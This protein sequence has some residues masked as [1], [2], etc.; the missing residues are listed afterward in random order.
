MSEKPEPSGT[1]IGVRVRRK[2]DRRHLQG[3]G[4][5][6]ADLAMPGLLEVAFLRSPVAHARLTGWRKAPGA[7]ARCFFLEDLEGL[8]PI[9]ARSSLKGYKVSEWPALARDKLRYVGEC[10]AACVAPTRAEAEDLAEACG[11]DYEELPAV[12]DPLAAR[13]AGSPLVHESW[14]DNLFLETF[15]DGDI[16][17]IARTAA[18]KVEREYATARQCM[19]PMEGKGLLAWWDDRADQLVVHTSTQVP[20][21]I[22]TGLAE[23]LG[24]E[25][26]RVRI[27]PPDVGGGF[28][29]K[30]ILQPEELVVAW[31]AMTYRRPFRWV[32]DRRE[33]L[34]AGANA[35]EHHYKVTAYADARGR[36]LALDAE[37][38]VNVG[39][40]SVYPFTACLEAAQAGGNL[41][42]PYDFRNYRCRTYSVAS[43]KPPFTPYRGV[44]RPGVCFAIELTIDAIARA[45][46]REPAEVRAENLVPGSAMPYDNVTNK[47]YDSGDYP[48]SLR[49][50]MARIDL[51]AVRTR[52][53]QGEPDGRLIGVGFSTF[54]EQSAHG[55]KVFASWGIPMVPGYEQATVRLT[56]EG[57]VEVRAGIH[58][59]GQGLETTLAQV[60][61]EILTIPVER[62]GVVLGDTAE[63]PYS[64][65]A[66][67]SRGAVMA[68][69]AVSRSATALAGQIKAIAAHLLQCEPAEVS[70]EGGRIRG[71]NASLDFADVGRAWY[72]NPEQLPDGVDARGLEATEGFKPKVDSGAF[73]YATHAAVVAVD[74]ETGK[75]EILDYVVIE[76]C[77]TMINPMIVEGQ[78]F[79]GS[80]QGIGTALFEESPYD[81]AGQPLHSTLADYLLPGPSELPSFRIEHMETPSPYTAHG[82]KGV[83]EGGAIAPPGAIV[84][85]INDAVK[86]LGVE[87]TE[88]PVSPRRLLGKILAARSGTPSGL[89]AA[90]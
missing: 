9:V 53:A 12:I 5:F 27:A 59:I 47:H 88:I 8:Q 10:V 44:A 60:A 54:T 71:G 15:V 77:G 17:A 18:V 42:G 1:G 20:H 58:T 46:G 79:G 2:E 31:L 85:A 6:V 34:V 56:P 24:L 63:T 87:M 86:G 25:Q 22:R 39:A 35:R 49:R 37:V 84:N 74:P 14:G 83:G 41:P 75:V 81:A 4:R 61:S 13:R 43:N 33:H 72:L 57:G 82:I 30:C 64:T 62:I 26:R 76:D 7:E 28:G 67:A 55:T 38:T 48:E 66:Y 19:H 3:R 70:F 80:A 50:A 23:C 73:T 32:E 21:V 78:A 65:G 40:Y 16:D 89:E 69:G 45:V 36:L 51:P 11:L 90:E 68:G 29:Y 52:Q